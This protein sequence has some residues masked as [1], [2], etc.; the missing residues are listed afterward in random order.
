[1]TS[2]IL[3]IA[4]IAAY[5]IGWVCYQT[6]LRSDPLHNT[7]TVQI[8]AALA[9]AMH[10]AA[11]V[12]L[13]FVDGGLDLSLLKI[14]PLLA[15]AINVLVWISGLKK[16]L[17]SLYLFLFPIS[18][19]SL[20]GALFSTST[21]PAL[22]MSTNLQAHVLISILAYSLLAIAALQA[23]LVGYQ[24]WQLK[25]KHQNLLMRAFPALQTME[26]LLFELIWAGQILL[27]LSLLSGFLFY[28]DFF[29]QKLVHKVVFSLLAWVVYAILLWGRH[30]RGWRGNKAIRWTWGGFIAIL[31]GFI[32]SKVVLEF[33]LNS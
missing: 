2:S 28:D 13:L 27:S 31:L 11:M 18:A 30:Y 5:L 16:P 26:V 29:A 19:L 10:G 17:H 24:N 7:K 14:L 8:I 23:L 20:L 12:S 9:V 21:K 6:Q 32:G 22:V 33:I 3:G 15:L 4:A 25:H 1:M